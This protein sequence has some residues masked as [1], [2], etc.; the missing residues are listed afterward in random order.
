MR[1]AAKAASLTASLLKHEPSQT[2]SPPTPPPPLTAAAAASDPH[3]AQP[4]MD[5]ARDALF[6]AKGDATAAQFRRGAVAVADAAATLPDDARRLRL[7]LRVDP[8]LRRRMKRAARHLARS[9]QAFLTDALDTAL[10]LPAVPEM[11]QTIVTRRTSRAPRVKLSVRADAARRSAV[12]RL[13]AALG[14]TMQAL[15]HA[16][17]EAHLARVLDAPASLSQRRPFDG[18]AGP[19]ATVLPFTAPAG[20]RHTTVTPL[21]QR[22]KPAGTPVHPS[23]H[24]RERRRAAG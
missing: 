15:L 2:P 5:A 12:R 11:R 8:R 19:G 24:P 22:A 4:V 18:V 1:S 9:N 16:A 14:C 6:F 20:Q 21:P 10:A 7:W 3:L 13:A 17:L 23:R